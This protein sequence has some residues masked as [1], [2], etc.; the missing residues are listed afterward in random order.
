MLQKVKIIG[1]GLAGSEAA[2]QLANQGFSVQLYEMRPHQSTVAHTGDKIAQ[3]VCSNSFK[4]LGKT[5]A[6]GL[7]KNE[8]EL[9]GSFLLSIAQ[10]ARVPAGESLTVDRDLF[11]DLV[12][13]KITSTQNITLH[14]EE[15][16]DF[17]ENIPTLVAAG[18]LASEALSQS[19]FKS[20]GSEKLHFFDAIA[21]VVEADS[22]D[23]NH[24]YYKNRW[25]R[26]ETADFI[27]CPLD[28]DT[29]EKIIDKLVEADSVEPKPFEKNELF[30]GCLP[31]E[32][33]ARR[34]RETLRYGPMRPVGLYDPEGKRW[35][36]V[37]QLRAENAQKTLFNMVGFQ[38]RLKWGTQKEVFS[39]IPALKNAQFVRLGCMHRNTFIES[40]KLLD[41]SLQLK[42]DIQTQ[43]KLPPLWFAGQITGA[44]GYTEAIATGWDA[45]WNM[46]NM[47]KNGKNNLLPHPSCIRSLVDHLVAPNPDFQPMN[48]NFGLVPN[49]EGFKKKEKKERQ[50]QLAEES[51]LEWIR[52]SKIHQ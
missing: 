20:L 6:H 17:S 45:A 34:G 51:V 46:A 12:E 31:I 14:R 50:A 9:L 2:L 4:G 25:E 24:A 30:E 19:I 11:S 21:P 5:T 52:E 22:I 36:A 27:N 37:V 16:V 43:S 13:K 42:R 3:L 28:K 40:P 29:Y 38:T 39:M 7:L 48:F 15:V 18:P 35:H 33:M 26:G 47:L 49:L 23:F 41:P 8:L 32:E 44:E 10:K 1:A